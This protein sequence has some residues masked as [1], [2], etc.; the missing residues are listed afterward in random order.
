LTLAI[1]GFFNGYLIWNESGHSYILETGLSSLILS[2]FALV[3]LNCW[4]VF[5]Q[6]TLCR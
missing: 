4:L 6:V 5:L 2:C 1:L 3:L